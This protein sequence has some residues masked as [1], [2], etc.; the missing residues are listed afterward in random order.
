MIIKL[1]FLSNHWALFSHF[2]AIKAC[3][4]KEMKIYQDNAGHMT[5]M[6]LSRNHWA[7]FDE[8]LYE[9]SDTLALY[10]LFKL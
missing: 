5:K 1:D 9:A 8:T 3:R 6:A 7:D 10:I 2:F 4:Y